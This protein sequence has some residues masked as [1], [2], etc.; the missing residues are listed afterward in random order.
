MF[1]LSAY[2][3]SNS[4][5]EDVH[6]WR[7]MGKGNYLRS[8]RLLIYIQYIYMCVWYSKSLKFWYLLR[9][10]TTSPYKLRLQS[11]YTAV[12][13]DLEPEKV[14]DYLFQDGI[15]DLDDMDDVKSEKTRKKRAVTL[16]EKVLRSGS[17]SLECFIN[18]LGKT[19]THLYDLLQQPIANENQL[20]QG[21][22]T[23]L[24]IFVCVSSFFYQ[25]THIVL[26]SFSL[27]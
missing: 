8:V 25:K 23:V 2:A 12:I 21:L 16:I 18:A 13:K 20:Q 9:N 11:N 17:Q 1:A 4:F 24:Y 7:L 26:H 3:L 10:M 22:C 5:R 14:L 27:P 6:E 15:V 19:Q